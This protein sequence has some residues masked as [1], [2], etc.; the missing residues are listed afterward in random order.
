[1]QNITE[2]IARADAA[3]IGDLLDAVL[4]RYGELYP[5]WDICTF[6]L[7]KQEDRDQQIDAAI[8]I[9]QRMRSPR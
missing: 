6:S 5:D 8:R 2:N 3:Q 1:M 4:K 9:L 7:C